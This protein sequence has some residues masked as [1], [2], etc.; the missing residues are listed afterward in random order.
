[1]EMGEQ[2]SA[3][4]RMVTQ[5]RSNL[6]CKYTP[7]YP[8]GGP[9]NRATTYEAK[10]S[11]KLREGCIRVP[12]TV[13]DK[14]TLR[15]IRPEA[16]GSGSPGAEKRAATAAANAGGSQSMTAAA[17]GGTA[18]GGRGN[19]SE[20]VG[21][22]S[23]RR[24]NDDDAASGRGNARAAATSAVVADTLDP[25]VAEAIQQG[26]SDLTDMAP[27][28]QF[29]EQALNILRYLGHC[30]RDS[31]RPS[32][33]REGEKHRCHRH[34]RRVGVSDIV[35]RS[36]PAR[37]RERPLPAAPPARLRRGG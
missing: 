3:S 27:C 4:F 9:H 21:G 8:G 5:S 23:R 25:A 28:H 6:R 26:I 34:Y 15:P 16:P 10:T 20:V 19:G 17:A 35:A 1:M 14:R 2:G 32:L 30:R 18:G 12:H 22:G 36:W 33:E 7:L 37:R 13:L 11:R 31:R 24:N 29:A